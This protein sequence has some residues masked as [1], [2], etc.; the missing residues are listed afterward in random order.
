MIQYSPK[1]NVNQFIYILNDSFGFDFIDVERYNKHDD[2]F[3]FVNNYDNFYQGEYGKITPMDN[4]IC[5]A[6]LIKLEEEE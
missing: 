4:F 3:L 1:A 5:H 2:N 6:E